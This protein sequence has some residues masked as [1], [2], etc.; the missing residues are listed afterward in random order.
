MK[1]ELVGKIRQLQM[2][3][4]IVIFIGVTVQCWVVTE[5]DVAKG[6][7]SQWGA[8]SETWYLWNGAIMLV[9]VATLFNVVWWIYKHPRLKY[10]KLYYSVFLFTAVCLFMVGLYPTGAYKYM[11]D[12]PAYLYFMIYP[13]AIFTMGFINRKRIHYNEWVRH[14]I[15]SLVMITLPLAFMNSFEGKAVPEILHTI[16]VIIWNLTLL[17]RYEVKRKVRI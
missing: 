4:S 6:Y 15:I 13:L 1:D 7:V 11:H 16:I 3:V 17:K 8:D 9:S 12:V 10:K 2:L 14:L 5:F